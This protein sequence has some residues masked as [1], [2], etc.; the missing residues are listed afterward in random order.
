MVKILIR[1]LKGIFS[2]K[3][4]LPFFKVA[5]A[6]A[7]PIAAQR[8]VGT[9]VNLLDNVMVGTLGDDFVSSAAIANQFFLL[10]TFVSGGVIGGAVL[11]SAQ[12]YG[13][14]NLDICKKMISL[15]IWLSILISL[16]FMGLTF[17]GAEIIIQIY[18]DSSVI[19]SPS[20]SYLR[21]IAWS[22]IPFA[23]T[24]A[25]TM[26]YRT[27]GSVKIGFYIE[28]V[29]CIVNVIFN[30]ILIFGLLG[31]PALGLNGAGI[32]TVIA[33][34]IGFVVV[35]IFVFIVD[36]KLKY[37]PS[38]LLVLPDKEMMKTFLVCGIPILFGDSFMM[39]NST[40]QTM[41]TGRIS[42]TYITANSI[43]HV[44]W[45]VAVLTAMGF[46]SAANIMI[47]NDI[48]VGDMEK[49]QKNGERFFL[50]SIV[51]GVIS[52]SLVL[53]VG[54]L[55]LSFYQVSDAA[56]EMARLMTYSASIVVVMMSIMMI[57]TKGVI[58]AGGK[59]REMMIVDIASSLGFGIP[60]GFLAAFIFKWP[61]HIIYVL[62]RG[63]YFVKGIW[64]ILQ[65]KRKDWAVRL[66]D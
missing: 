11:I 15:S 53:L 65:L 36:K 35:L 40:L 14:K 7:L 3:E 21:I 30:A 23:L 51:Q 48:G 13:N 64:G 49:A 4:L 17:K 20:S 2:D 24:T 32:A 19:L 59:T 29:N 9:T 50:L 41:I 37:K 27:V 22:F 39:I 56:I 26:L 38:D 8:V 12:A 47:G 62:I 1:K 60:L 63:D 28:F 33:R 34:W 45:Q 55:I 18:S 5:V 31:F 61:A 16:I 6:L 42:D 54:P 43:V 52:A 58:R 10:F 46:E 44:I 25:L 57:T 66:V